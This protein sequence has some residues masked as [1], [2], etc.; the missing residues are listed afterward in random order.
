MEKIITNGMGAA[1][2]V[3]IAKY[4]R[5]KHGVQ[6]SGDEQTALAAVLYAAFLIGETIVRGAFTAARCLVDRFFPPKP[7]PAAPGSAE[8]T[9]APPTP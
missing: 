3:L 4:L 7:A 9:P 1:L 8:S 5:E 6:F 2:A